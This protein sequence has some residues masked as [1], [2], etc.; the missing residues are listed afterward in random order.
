MG[1]ESLDI[2][3]SWF[4]HSLR[5]K[6]SKQTKQSICSDSLSWELFEKLN[7]CSVLH[8]SLT[9]KRLRL[10]Y[11]VD[12]CS[13][14]C[15]FHVLQFPVTVQIPALGYTGNSKLF[16][17]GCL[18]LQKLLMCPACNSNWT[19]R[20]LGLAPNW[21]FTEWMKPLIFKTFTFTPVIQISKDANWNLQDIS[22][23]R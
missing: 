18:S 14:V 19:Q 2:H 13:C 23:N 11:Y 15:S 1:V 3:N 12:F 9:T 10:R 4:W 20:Q 17:N 6:C 8:C 5:E 22:F 21:L 7:W 16:A